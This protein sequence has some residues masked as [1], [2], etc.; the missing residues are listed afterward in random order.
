M[1][2]L[3]I[4]VAAVILIALSYWISVRLYR[5]CEIANMFSLCQE[6][7]LFDLRESKM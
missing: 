7:I 5:G 1:K 4:W 6:D 3:F 2:R